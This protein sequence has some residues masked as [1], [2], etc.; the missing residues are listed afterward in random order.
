MRWKLSEAARTALFSAL[1]QHRPGTFAPFP[2]PLLIA[3]QANHASNC[4]HRV[5]NCGC[6]GCGLSPLLRDKK[7]VMY[8]C[9]YV[10]KYLV[11]HH[12]TACFLL[13]HLHAGNLRI[14][15]KKKPVRTRFVRLTHNL[16]STSFFSILDSNARP[17]DKTTFPPSTRVRKTTSSLPSAS[18]LPVNHISVINL[19]PGMTGAA[20]RAWN[21]FSRR[22]SEAPKVFSTACAAIFHVQ[23]PCRIAPGNPIV[24]PIEGSA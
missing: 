5:G 7:L 14:S 18:F 16:L 15:K 21:C 6:R 24:F 23:R 12:I 19:S 9:L 13:A 2:P 8:V 4:R 10:A 20:K 22:A 17:F 3:K 1:D 11:H